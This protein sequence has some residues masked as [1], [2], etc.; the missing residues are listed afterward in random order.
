MGTDL[1]ATDMRPVPKHSKET[2]QPWSTPSTPTTLPP[3]IDEEDA[4]S[5]STGI[6]IGIVLGV[7][8]LILAVTGF[9]YYRIRRRVSGDRTD[10]SAAAQFAA[11]TTPVGLDRDVR[12]VQEF[13][14]D[15]MGG[16]RTALVGKTKSG[17]KK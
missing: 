13:Q 17:K 5:T 3:D 15:E 16:D 6:I 8:V 2:T 11:F 10:G 4:D 12:N 9:S 1:L 14:M 7:L